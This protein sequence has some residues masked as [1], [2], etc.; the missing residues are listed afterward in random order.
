MITNEYGE[1]TPSYE[2]EVTYIANSASW[3]GRAYECY[4]CHSEF[5]SLKALNQHLASP[6]HQEKNFICPNRACRQSFVAVSGLWQHVESERC[7]VIK[8]NGVR[9]QL[10]GLMGGMRLLTS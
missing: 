5:G 8:F 2:P 7:G 6:K 9:Q 4:L 10:D 1:S 3:N